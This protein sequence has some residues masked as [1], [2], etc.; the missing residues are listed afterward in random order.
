MISERGREAPDTDNSSTP[1]ETVPGDPGPVVGRRRRSG[2]LLKVAG[3]LAALILAP[4]LGF[5]MYAATLPLPSDPASAAPAESTRLLDRQGRLLV[6]L[7]PGGYHHVVP[8]AAMP[9][10]LVAGTV[11]AEDAS[12]YSN[13]GVEP[14]AI[15]RALFLDLRR[16]SGQLYGGSTLTQ[17]LV[18]TLLLSPQERRSGSLTRKLHEAAL[19]LRL[20]RLL[21][22]ERI[23]ALYLNSVYYGNLAY[24][25]DAA[26]QV[27]FGQPVSSLDLAQCAL[28]AGLP[29]APAFYD[30]LRHPEAA[31]RRQRDVLRLMAQ[32]GAISPGQEAQAAAEPLQFVNGM[33]HGAAP[34]F[35]AYV[36]DLLEERLGAARVRQGGLTV[37]TSLDL[38]L[39]HV[40]EGIVARRVGALAAHNAHDGALVAL[41]PRTGEVLALVGSAD[42]TNRRI[43]GAVDVALS[44]RQPGSAIK[45]FTYA[46]A[47]ANGLSPATIVS[48]VPTTFPT[49][50][51]DAY[52]PQNYDLQFH[53]PVPLRVALAS[54][55]NVPSVALLQRVGLGRMLGLAHAAGMTTMNDARRYGLA[56]TLGG[57]E[58]RLLDLTS[59]YGVFAAGGV[60]HP[61]LALLDVRDSHG[62]VVLAEAPGGGGQV[63]GPHGVQV[64]YLITDVLSDPQARLLGFGEGSP[65][66]LPDQPGHF[67]AA[68]K[69][70]TTGNWRDNWTVGYTP[71]LV[72]GVWVGNA[73]NSPMRD[74]SGV[75]GAAPIWRDAMEAA[76]RGRSAVPFVRPPG[77]VSLQVCA[78]SGNL[79]TAFC[80]HQR[81]ETFI[82]GQQPRQADTSWRQVTVDSAT[83]RTATASTPPGRR[84][85][86]LYR[87][88][89]PEARAWARDHGYPDLPAP[90]HAGVTTRADPGGLALTAPPRQAVYQISPSLPRGNQRIAIAA[91]ALSASVSRVT[92]SVDGRSVG[93]FTEPP[94]SVDWPLQAGKHVVAVA[95][96]DAAG[97]P[98]PGQSGTITVLDP[99]PP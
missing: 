1:V 56:L 17:Q 7:A 13:P 12:F 71:D 22:K 34:H 85:T 36:V 55:L 40:A 63:L 27:Y 92:L 30:P 10:A 82:A 91:Q 81:L 67:G 53:G 54:S 26:A 48:D 64:A 42:P 79:P 83:G 47:F 23:L 38:D 59:A 4:L 8:L 15:G 50:E 65:L 31:R 11:A 98:V 18:R 43:S 78:E 20:T 87:L 58:V 2:R 39:Q 41:D 5:A 3:A 68:V 51:G 52:T 75:T 44:P 21:P 89:P 49:R 61:P 6:D 77:L 62:Q 28:L 90:A 66:E 70:G 86:R 29:R 84:V 33:A 97:R 72:V 99:A 80:P 35:T 60:R 9:A 19:A 32:R 46:A 93:T 95:G 96:W 16:D 69:T 14:L 45:P 57:G 37:R 25:V 88:F 74:V 94:Y 76:L 73:D 24:G